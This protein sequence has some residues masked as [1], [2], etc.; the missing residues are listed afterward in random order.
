M[1]IIRLCIVLLSFG[2]CFPLFITAQNSQTS[3]TTVDRLKEHVVYLASDELEGRATG[4]EG[5]KLAYEYIIAAFEKAGLQPKGDEGSFLQAFNFVAGRK[6]V[7][8]NYLTIGK[9]SLQIDD[10]YFPMM[11]SGN[12]TVEGE[13]TDVG[14]GIAAPDI[15]H[16]D[17]ATRKILRDHIF[18]IYLGSPDADN[19]HSKYGPYIDV[20]YKIETAIEQ[21]AKGIVFVN[22][23]EKGEAPIVDVKKN[24]TKY[25][26]PIVYAHKSALDKLKGKRTTFIKMA[27]GVEKVEK[28]GHNVI[29]F[30]DNQAPTTVVLGGHYDHLGHGESGGS[31]HTGKKAIHNGADD[32]ASG[33]ALI[34][35]MAKALQDPLY[36]ANNYLFIGF[37]GEELGLFGSSYFTK[38]MTVPLNTLNYMLNYDMVGRLDTADR[39]LS[40]NGVGTSP[41]WSVINEIKVDDMV[42]KTTDSGIGSSDHSSFYWQKVPA[43]HFFSGQHTDYHK[44]DDDAEKVNYEGIESVMKFTLALIDSLDNDTAK[45]SFT[46]T[47]QVE[48]KASKFKVTLGIMPDYMFDD[49][50]G[51]KVSGIIDGRPAQAAGLAAEDLIIK[52]GEHTISDIYEYMDA[53]S[54]FNKGDATTV[55]VMRKGKK[56]I[57]KLVF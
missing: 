33:T 39:K 57:L 6:Y 35:E 10:T 8:D 56:L 44:P 21:G 40:I 29:G 15:H 47:K 17:Y 25:D 42:I 38:N 51:V 9:E 53:L 12:G 1:I 45:L 13:L 31:L 18:Q 34:I 48:R 24:T 14:Y 54:H 16:N 23:D 27:T 20:Q 19:P 43:I 37:S 41:A 3:S 7:G 55:S 52:L 50:A 5:E 49:E 22:K 32:N 36:K 11:E 28:T 2:M 30:W 26:I 4:S 46:T